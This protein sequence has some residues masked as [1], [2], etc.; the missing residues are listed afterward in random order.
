[1]KAVVWTAYGPPGVLQIRQVAKPSPRDNEVLV[2]VHASTVTTGDCEMRKL[3]L[4]LF[5]SFPMRLYAGFRKPKRITIF[6]QE[7]AGEVEEVGRQVK[8][9][10]AGDPVF[11][12]TTIRL[13]GYA[14]YICVPEGLLA[15]KPSN[16]TYEQAAAV[17]L[18][19]QE[20]LYYLSKANIRS[21]QKVLV[22]GAGGSIG[23][24]AVQLARQS[25]AEVTAVDRAS[26]LDMLHS[27]GAAHVI[28][29]LHE[30]FTPGGVM[31]DVIFD[32]VGKSPFPRSLDS[33]KEQG[34][35]LVANPSLSHLI[36]GQRMAKKRHKK[37]I[38]GKSEQKVEDLLQVKELI[39]A[40]KITPVIDR[41]Y[42]LEQTAEAHAYVETGEKKGSV[43]ITLE[44]LL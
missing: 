28:D 33:I 23:T 19:G 43:V 29:Y 14:E 2:R 22:Y 12:T 5:F 36:R 35:Y 6:G 17:P 25:G 24:M 20:S 3:K 26:K 32:V 9:F 10:K 37:M 44:H 16:L 18:G 30:D 40:G 13:G 4:P 39:E 41:I 15:P 21:G 34:Y 31:Y 7:L 8:R 1:M 11:G 27:N 42:P 38:A